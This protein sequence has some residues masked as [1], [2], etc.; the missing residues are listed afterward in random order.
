MNL[1][2]ANRSSLTDMIFSMFRCGVLKICHV[3]RT[4][5]MIFSMFRCGVLNICHVA[6]T[7]E[8]LTRPNVERSVFWN[9]S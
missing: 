6:R 7:S 4:S 2:E 1:R 9:L 3:A 8:F 5:D